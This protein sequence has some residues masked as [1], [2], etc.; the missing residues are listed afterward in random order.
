MNAPP[1]PLN[2]SV[3]E[4]FGNWVWNGSRW[5]STR[6]TGIQV[7]TQVFT[8]AGQS[9]YQ[10]SPGLVSLV[11]ECIGGGGGGGATGV[12]AAITGGAGGGGSGAWSR[13]TLPAALVLGGVIVT[14]G[15]GGAA[16]LT[17][18]SA[19][20]AGG[21]TSFGAFCSAPG[22]GGGGPNTG[23]FPNLGQPGHGGAMGVG[24]LTFPGNPG[25]AGVNFL[26]TTDADTTTPV[27]YGAMGG[28][29]VGGQS[30]PPS[31]AG[32]GFVAGNPGLGY[33][34]GGGA[35]LAFGSDTSGNNAA[36]APGFAG[37]CVVT[38]YC[39]GDASDD[40]CC[41]QPPSATVALRGHLTVDSRGGKPGPHPHGGQEAF[42]PYGWSGDDDDGST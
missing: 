26:L 35:G 34:A 5:V 6:A 1:F 32:G 19:G 39:W 40:D 27:L 22:G 36:G 28:V 37:V 8:T 17:N 3:G 15:P 41:A 10:P 42:E 24:D 16:G 31:S 20:A 18:G 23:L 9:P 14:V 38:E 11:V 29:I 21:T 13:K 12:D 4:R 33:G 25:H 2:P 7:I 30:F